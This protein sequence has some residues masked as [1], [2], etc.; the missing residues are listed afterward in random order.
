M[1][2]I[3][4]LEIGTHFRKENIFLATVSLNDKNSKMAIDNIMLEKLSK[5]GVEIGECEMFGIFY[6]EGDVYLR[7]F[8]EDVQTYVGDNSDGMGV[9]RNIVP[10]WDY[11]SEDELFEVQIYDG[12]IVIGFTTEDPLTRY[13]FECNLGNIITLEELRGV[14]EY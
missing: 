1:A 14:K 11:F 13:N 3:K 12:S 10:V 5:Y 7:F 4:K 6:K 9:L 8:L 2:L